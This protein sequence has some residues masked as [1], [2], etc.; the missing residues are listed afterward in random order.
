MFKEENNIS[1]PTIVNIKAPKVEKSSKKFLVIGITL[2]LCCL[3]FTTLT[4]VSGE[5]SYNEFR[6]NVILLTISMLAAIISFIYSIVL[7]AKPNLRTVKM[8]I[9]YLII[10]LLAGYYS[11]CYMNSGNCAYITFIPHMVSL[12]ISYVLIFISLFIKDEK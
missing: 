8:V 10:N 6:D 11:L 5:A 1:Q 2:N 12:F 4:A 7:L 3:L 9:P